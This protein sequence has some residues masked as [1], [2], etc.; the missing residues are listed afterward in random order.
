MRRRK[1]ERRDYLALLWLIPM[2]PGAV[3]VL[4]VIGL[5][6]LA[7]LVRLGT[8]SDRCWVILR[9]VGPVV[10]LVV[11]GAVVVAVVVWWLRREQVG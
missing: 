10:G 3:V 2:I 7:P 4:W 9:W 5:A 11:M 8:W 1:L 6:A